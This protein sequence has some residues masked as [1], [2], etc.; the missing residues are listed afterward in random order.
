MRIAGFLI[1]LFSALC[2]S[3]D[4]VL[5]SDARSPA[6]IQLANSLS[7]RLE[8]PVRQI[9]NAQEA[10]PEDIVIL[11]GEDAI[12][13][14]R[15]T[16]PSIG[17]WARRS[18][19]DASLTRIS[20]AIYSEPPLARQLKLAQILFP[21]SSVSLMLSESAPAWLREEIAALPAEGL[22]IVEKRRDENLNYALRKALSG[23]D[24][25]LGTPD[26]EIFN[27]GTIKNI[28]I[29]AYRQN[30]PLIGPH[31]AYLRA[32]AIVTTFSSLD[33]TVTRIIEIIRS[34]ELPAPD[35]NPYFT[36][37][38][39]EQVARSLD[40][41]LPDSPDALVKRIRAQP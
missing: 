20:S 24:V 39:N 12:T 25:L 35:Y 6:L 27:P 9:Q 31:Q 2:S 7:E 32:G 41:S 1:L 14:W 34:E 21:E 5:L 10:S 19:I 30:I 29:S 26:T 17:I 11:A 38:F 15:G 4:V 8:Q 13:D 3:A 22:T 40:V 23:H 33:D 36:I 37:G 16:Q 28:L 18:A